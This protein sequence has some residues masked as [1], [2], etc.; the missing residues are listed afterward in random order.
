MEFEISV[1]YL[2]L[3]PRLLFS[4]I[5]SHPFFLSFFLHSLVFSSL[6]FLPHLLSACSS[7]F[8]SL[9][10]LYLPFSFLLPF[11]PVICT[12]HPFLLTSLSSFLTLFLLPYLS[13]LLQAFLQPFFLPFLRHFLSVFPSSVSITIS[14]CLS[15]M[16]VPL[17]S[18]PWSCLGLE[19]WGE[20]VQESVFS[21]PPIFQEGRN[22]SQSFPPDL[23]PNLVLL[24]QSLIYINMYMYMPLDRFPRRGYFV[25]KWNGIFMVEVIIFYIMGRRDLMA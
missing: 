24:T 19:G 25:W 13:F 17:T 8:S 7:T 18:Y 14:F 21:L 9:F 16:P 22:W 5:V 20:G 11:L 15:S 1:I 4:V 3:P 23:T 12:N 10:T 6:L 2:F